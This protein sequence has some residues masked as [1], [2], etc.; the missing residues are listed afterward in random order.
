MIDLPKGKKTFSRRAVRK[1]LHA[2][3]YDDSLERYAWASRSLAGSF[4]HGEVAPLLV[5]S[6]NASGVKDS[7]TCRAVHLLLQ[8]A[9]TLISREKIHGPASIFFKHFAFSLGTETGTDA[10]PDQCAAALAGLKEA[11]IRTAL[12]S[13]I[14]VP[15]D[16]LVDYLGYRALQ[17]AVLQAPSQPITNTCAPGSAAGLFAT[18]DSTD[19][20]VPF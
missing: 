7:A 13:D 2:Q 20:E 18:D 9:A 15:H 5:R 1:L 10:A 6:I 17:M 16:T 4:E 12:E 19:D 3:S 14:A 11:R 8:A